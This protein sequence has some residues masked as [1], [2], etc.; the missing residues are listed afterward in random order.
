MA[1]NINPTKITKDQAL[2]VFST[3]TNDEIC[4][5]L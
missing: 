4:D 5:A 3:G 1:E 2:K